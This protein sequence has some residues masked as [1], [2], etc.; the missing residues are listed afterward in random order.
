MLKY[1]FHDPEILDANFADLLQE[2]AGESSVL[3][4]L[5][6]DAAVNEGVKESFLANPTEN[7]RIIYSVG[8]QDLPGLIQIEDELVA[9]RELVRKETPNYE[10]SMRWGD[11]KLELWQSIKIA[12]LTKINEA[13]AS[14]RLI[15]A[16]IEGDMQT[17]D[18]YNRYLYGDPPLSMLSFTLQ[19]M[20][21]DVESIP[22]DAS[23]ALKIAARDVQD[24]LDNMENT[25][26]RVK[27]S[28]DP[29]TTAVAGAQKGLRSEM[30]G[31]INIPLEAEEGRKLTAE[32][33]QV[34]YQEIVTEILEAEGW[35]VVV[36]NKGRGIVVDNNVKE[37]RIPSDLQMSK[38]GVQKLALHEL[39]IHVG[40]Y[41][42][43]INTKVL[44]LGL[45]LDRSGEFEEGLAK[46]SETFADPDGDYLGNDASFLAVCLARGI[47]GIKRDFKDVYEWMYRYYKFRKL[48]EGM[49]EGD[50]ETSAKDVAWNRCIRTFRGTDCKT[51]GVCLNKEIFYRKGGFKVVEFL[52]QSPDAVASVRMAKFDPTRPYHVALLVQLGLT[53]EDL[54]RL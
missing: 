6:P 50:A 49:T 14:V 9:L 43:G 10:D 28:S 5:T 26:P 1:D 45:G 11:E 54:N 29:F 47:D 27:A 41:V 16:S 17:F 48:K 39:G 19:N 21:E 51:P 37:V 44:I 4:K 3:D 32:E 35:R 46:L 12:Y 31:I 23:V 8:E 53:D 40:R 30:E 36:V 2:F 33:I 42:N 15:I 18:R 13:R 22:D 24:M 20:K 52:A 25:L 38:K 34:Y 7:P